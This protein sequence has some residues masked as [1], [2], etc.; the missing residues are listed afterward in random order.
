MTS[1]LRDSTV[2]LNRNICCR[3]MCFEHERHMLLNCWKNYIH[4]F[5]L[6][7]DSALFG[8]MAFRI[9]CENFSPFPLNYIHVS[10]TL[11]IRDWSMMYLHLYINKRQSVFAISQPQSFAN[12]KPSRKCLN[13][14]YSKERQFIDSSKTKQCR[15]FSKQ[16]AHDSI[17]F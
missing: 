16:D 11:K 1:N 3:D 9:F 17:I 5:T 8:P 15:H 2:F 12:K 7:N 6:K 10:A 14:Q 13:K 4:S